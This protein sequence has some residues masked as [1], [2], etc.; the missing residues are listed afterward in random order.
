[1]EYFAVPAKKLFPI[2]HNT[3]PTYPLYLSHKFIYPNEYLFS[4]YVIT[5]YLQFQ[6][7]YNYNKTNDFNGLYYV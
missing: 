2:Y 4:N 6:E 1:M 3:P 5:F 7:I